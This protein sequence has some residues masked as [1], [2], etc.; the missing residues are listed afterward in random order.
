MFYI[1]A[2]SGDYPLTVTDLRLR[3]PNVSF[4]VTLTDAEAAAFDC[5]P[6][7]ETAQPSAPG[8]VA[9][10]GAPELVGGVWRERWALRSLTESETGALQQG[11]V[12]A[13]QQRLDDFART[14]NYDGILS[15]ATYATST[16]PQFATEGQYAVRARDATWAALYTILG[17][18]QAGTRPVPTSFADIEQDLPVLAWPA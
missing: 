18:V 1:H 2:P 8:K 10:R 13:A 9:V 5:Y 4:P 14:R 17:Q 7:Q 6:V 12:A 11:I 16:V 15:A 3:H